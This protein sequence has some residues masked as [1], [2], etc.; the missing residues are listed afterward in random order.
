MRVGPSEQKMVGTINKL[1]AQVKEKKCVQGDMK[2]M[3]SLC[4]QK[5]RNFLNRQVLVRKTGKFTHRIKLRYEVI[6]EES[7]NVIYADDM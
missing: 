1:G 2:T 3:S 5:Y 6:E 7:E 4:C